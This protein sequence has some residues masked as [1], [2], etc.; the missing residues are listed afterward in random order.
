MDRLTYPDIARIFGTGL[1]ATGVGLLTFVLVTI[2]WGDPF[3]RAGEHK[4]QQEL[5]KDFASFT[6]GQGAL[7]TTSLDPDLTRLLAARYGKSLARGKGAGE[8]RIPAIGL[9]KV[10]INGAREPDLK[11]GPGFYVETGFPGSGAAVAI[12]GHRTTWGAPFLDIDKLK[13]GNRILIDMPY[14]RFTYTVSRHRIIK[15]TDWSIIY[16]GQAEPGKGQRTAIARTGIC[17]RG[18]CEHLVMTACHPKYSAAQRYAVFARLTKVELRG[19]AR[20]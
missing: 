6:K 3:T 11:K 1:I 10:V 4:A 20:A 8:L 12:A 2:T 5:E 17:P 14:G 7:H 19:G 16:P 15:P 18:T 13:P 9:H